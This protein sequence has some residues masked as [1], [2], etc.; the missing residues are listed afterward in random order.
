MGSSRW[1]IELHE[2]EADTRY[3]SIF[4]AQHGGHELY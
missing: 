3:D 1:Y 2:T 4:H